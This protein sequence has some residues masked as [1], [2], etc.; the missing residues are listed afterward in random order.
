MKTLEEMSVTDTSLIPV[1]DQ[2]G[3]TLVEVMVASLIML[4]G[5]FGIVAAFP[6]ALMATVKSG[7]VTVLNHM[8]GAKMDELRTR[9]Y[10]HADLAAGIHPTIALDAGG[11]WYYPVPGL[12]EAY[13]LRW[14]VSTGPT[15][16]G[17]TPVAGMKTVVVEATHL[18]RY[19]AGGLPLANPVAEQ[20]FF[21]TY[22]KE[23]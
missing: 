17:G 8:A 2:S 18:L 5:V 7:H 11:S 3:F 9:G 19:S 15:D 12:D 14:A 6:Q 20:V 21:Q 13:S 22:L 23:E 1:K 4:I 10:A 16:S